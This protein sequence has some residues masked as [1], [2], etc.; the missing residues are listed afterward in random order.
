M[1]SRKAGERGARSPQATPR[2]GELIILAERRAARERKS[3]ITRP[4]EGSQ[5]SDWFIPR[6]MRHAVPALGVRVG[7]YF[8]TFETDDI[9]PGDFIS[10]TVKR[11]GRPIV[12]RLLEANPSHM[13]VAFVTG[14]WWYARRELLIDGRI[15]ALW[16]GDDYVEP[17][18]RLRAVHP[19]A[20]IYQFRKRA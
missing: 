9:E 2:Q 6:R 1:P 15:C 5:A 7:D 11:T 19:T 14:E 4:P 12:A 8:M 18:V 13:R 20:T 3:P 10:F 17:V 16:R